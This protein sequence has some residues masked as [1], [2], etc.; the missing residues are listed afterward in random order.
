MFGP[1]RTANSPY[2]VLADGDSRGRKQITRVQLQ[3]ESTGT[4]NME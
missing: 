3:G 4:Y 1:L 2:S